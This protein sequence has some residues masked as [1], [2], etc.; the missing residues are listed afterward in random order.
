MGLSPS[1]VAE[2][3]YNGVTPQGN[4]GITKVQ[5]SRALSYLLGV[6]YG[7]GCCPRNTGIIRL[8]VKD[9]DFVEEF[10]RCL[11]IVL[12]RKD[13]PYPIW[14]RNDGRFVTAGHSVVLHKFLSQSLEKHNEIVQKFPAVFI[15]GFADSEGTPLFYQSKGRKYKEG[16]IIISNSDSQLLAYIQALLAKYFDIDSLIRCVRRKR[17]IKVIKGVET[18]TS[19]PLFN[20]EINKNG[21]LVKYF[22]KIGFTIRRKQKKLE[23]WYTYHLTK[24]RT[25]RKEGYT[26]QYCGA[27][28]RTPQSLGG[29]VTAVHTCADLDLILLRKGY[30]KKKGD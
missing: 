30:K 28:F 3:I 22:K 13:N 19:K 1:T 11:S 25:Y 2:W 10:S 14:R 15:R 17:I 18:K 21:S 16:R 20:L 6:V 23:E 8:E 12:K 5:P 26:C 7:D 29:H 24:V 27:V 4:Y 9:R